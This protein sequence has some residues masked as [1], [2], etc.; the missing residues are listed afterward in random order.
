MRGS[1]VIGTT[2]SDATGNFAFT[3][4]VTK[5]YSN[6]KVKWVRSALRAR[7]SSARPSRSR[8]NSLYDADHDRARQPDAG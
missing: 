7:T 6:Y 3:F 1:T 5:T 2:L 8:S 4:K